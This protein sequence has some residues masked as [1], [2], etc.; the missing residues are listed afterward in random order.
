M[1]HGGAPQPPGPPP[2]AGNGGSGKG[3]NGPRR[4]SVWLIALVSGLIGGLLVLLPMTVLMQSGWLTPYG[5]NDRQLQNAPGTQK[6]V[7]VSVNSDIINAA[8]KVRPAV[9]GVV[10][11]QETGDPFNPGTVQKGTGSG[12]IFEKVGGNVRIITNNHVIA[13]AEKVQVV[14]PKDNGGAKL[15]AKILGADPVTDL[16]VLEIPARGIKTIATLGNSDTLQPGEPAIA[17]GNP[18][19][20]DFSQSV[21]VGVISSTKRSIQV[22]ETTAIDVIQTDAAINPGNSGGALVNAAGQVIGINTL[23]IAEQ[24][25]EGLGFAIPINEAKPII[26]DLIQHG[27]VI[28]PYLGISLMDLEALPQEYWSELQLPDNVKSGIIIRD[29]Q[30]G[31]P[32]D[33]AGLEA[34]DVIVAVDG[35]PVRTAAA[36][37]KYLYNNKKVGDT[38]T[39]T[40]YRG[41]SKQS[42]TVRLSEQ[43]TS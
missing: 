14:L 23:K 38:I 40:Y 4:A 28:R 41:S 39:I 30:P 25:V 17:I 20:L 26:Q 19:G 5:A 13:G 11:L 33:Q 9:V 35:K 21:T 36:F 8:K 34:H 10:N 18:L 12:I 27:R 42:A 7:S 24:G 32:A 16:A 37:R 22:N 6:N 15:T 29:V 43:P 3:E 2:P 1:N 31:T